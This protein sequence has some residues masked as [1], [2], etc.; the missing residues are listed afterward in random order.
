[1]SDVKRLY[2]SRKDQM[3]AG[4]CAGLGD[5]LNIDPTIIRLLFVALA[6]AGGP[7]VIAYLILWVVTPEEP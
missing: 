2:R 1:M 7:G 3:L 5:Y 4:V 6:L